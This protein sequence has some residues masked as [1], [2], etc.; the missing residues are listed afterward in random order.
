[1]AVIFAFDFDFDFELDF[2]FN[3]GAEALREADALPF[4][5]PAF[6]FPLAFPADFFA[7]GF[8]AFRALVFAM[9]PP[10]M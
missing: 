8:A 9:T 7:A 2:D 6:A 4:A 10:V 5:P 1:L 3:F